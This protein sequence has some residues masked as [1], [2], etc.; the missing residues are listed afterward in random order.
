MITGMLYR[1]DISHDL[2]NKNHKI[3]SLEWPNP[4]DD[5]PPG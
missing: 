4:I 2:V 1:V 3:R 5:A